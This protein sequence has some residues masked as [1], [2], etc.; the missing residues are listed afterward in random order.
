MRVK[1]RMNYRAKTS[2][3]ALVGL[4]VLAAGC[5]NDPTNP[6]DSQASTAGGNAAGGQAA[7]SGA[8][9]GGADSSS[10]AG[11]DAAGSGASGSGAAGS[12][13]G[14][15]AK[16][17]GA[18]SV[19]PGKADANASGTM[20]V[21][22]YQKPSGDFGPLAP[23]SGPDQQ[24]ISLIY[25][26]LLQ[27]SPK[28]DLTP[29][30][31]Q[32]LPTVSDGGK[33]YTFKLKPNLKWSDGTPLTSEDVLFSYTRAADT[34][35]NSGPAPNFATIAGL[36]D[37]ID[38]KAK[39]IKGFSAPDPQTF[40]MKQDIA[41]SGL[42]AQAGTLPIFP[43]HI[44]EKEPIKD[45]N[46]N[47]WFKKPTVTSGPFTFVEYKT[48]QYA[49]VQ[50]NP[51]FREPVGVKDIYVKPMSADVA[52][53]QLQTGE[54]DLV[55][56]GA[57]DIPTVE[58]MQGVKVQE[59]PSTGFVTL[60]WNQTQDRFKDKRVRQ[61]FQYAVDRKAIADGALQGHAKVRN[62]VFPEK[63]SGT[64]IND[65]AYNPDKAKQLLAEAK[66]DTSKPIDLGWIAGGNPDRDAAAQVV[67]D[68][69]KKVGLNVNLKQIQASYFVDAF[70]D[71]H[72]FD[73][74]L[75]GGGDYGV[76]PAGAGPVT[77][78]K[79]G[80]PKGPNTGN[81]CNPEMD[82]AM[83]KALVA[84]TPEQQKTDYQ[85]AAKIE[86]EDP[87]LGWLYSLNWTFAVSDKVQNFQI[88]DNATWYQPWLWKKT[89]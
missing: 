41:N 77:N 70:N 17:G 8:A 61:A 89:G 35:T 37:Y 66:F 84:T 54:M 24:V 48:D 56:I 88:L 83:A 60:T 14:S 68:Q 63:W 11:G 80:V 19:E 13:A 69:L 58:G 25:D 30:M 4:A 40:V 49:H 57:V 45:F 72:K 82:K 28:G 43:K 26:E 9:G 46:L 52:T 32:G 20:N 81:Y 12:A 10:A 59:V 23:A 38:G 73:V 65:Y 31:A 36:Q 34:R 29:Y 78:C 74:L 21:F 53:Q 64:D 55:Q 2:V 51:N 44:L 87:A 33:T 42:P 75:V 27:K 15:A 86:N 1:L 76:N 50:A 39:T 62:S 85:A 18:G 3:A 22:M 79:L 6:T 16:A 47:K 71:K 7:G 67:A 5:S